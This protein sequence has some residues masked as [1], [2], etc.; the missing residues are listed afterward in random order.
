MLRHYAKHLRGD[1][2]ATQQA[3]AAISSG[4]NGA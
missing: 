1:D 2:D 4:F 3:L